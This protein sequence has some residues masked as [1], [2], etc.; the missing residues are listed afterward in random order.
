MPQQ[1]LR[2]AHVRPP[3]ALVL[4]A[5]VNA[6]AVVTAHVLDGGEQGD[7]V[8]WCAAVLGMFV[9]VGVLG[10]FRRTIN[11]RQSDGRFADWRV[12]S[13]SIVTWSTGIAWLAGLAH[14]FL[15]CYVLTRSIA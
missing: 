3:L 13:S 1:R 11:T 6:T 12:S 10:L 9:A 8:R 5:V 2:G 15:A 14:L 7:I 4:L